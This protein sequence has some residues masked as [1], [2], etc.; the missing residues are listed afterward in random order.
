VTS[1]A[2]I[3]VLALL[4]APL[5]ARAAPDHFADDFARALGSAKARGVPLVVDVWAPW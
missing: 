5:L 2:K 3:P 4:A 1:L